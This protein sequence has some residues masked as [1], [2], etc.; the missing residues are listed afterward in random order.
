LSYQARRITRND[1]PYYRK[2]F[3]DLDGSRS[4]RAFSRAGVELALASYPGFHLTAPPAEAT[5]FGVF[6]A[7]YVPQHAITQTVIY[8]DGHRVHVPPPSRTRPAPEPLP[9]DG[10]GGLV[11]PGRY[12]LGDLFGA[13]SGDKG[14][15]A[16]LGVWARDDVGYELLRVL[17]TTSRLRRLLPEVAELAVERYPLPNL[18]AVNFVIRGLLGE[19]VA[20]STRF[21]PQAKALGE[22]LR[23]MEVEISR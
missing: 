20:A 16:N 5:P 21:D 15:D 7:S 12:R 3:K 1:S 4:G 23:S 8:A 9:D 22:W 14:G 2:L 19:G 18:R 13:R 10:E 11:S 6:S 17:L